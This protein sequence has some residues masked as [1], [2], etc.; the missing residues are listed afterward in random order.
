MLLSSNRSLLPRLLLAL[1]CASLAACEQS[2]PS[3][4]KD[5]SSCDEDFYLNEV[6]A[7]VPLVE[8]ANDLECERGYDCL[9]ND[10]AGTSTCHDAAVCK[11]GER[12]PPARHHELDYPRLREGVALGSECPPMEDLVF[13][14]EE[15]AGCQLDGECGPAAHDWG[16]QY[17]CCYLG[18]MVC[19][20]IAP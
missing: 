7:C 19:G 18:E 11:V 6:G 17:V 1:L 20:P 10:L 8:C 4:E 12:T 2:G 14:P 3:H 16:E 13:V 5:G 9:P 15:P